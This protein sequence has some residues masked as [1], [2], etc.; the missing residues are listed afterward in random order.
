MNVCVIIP[1]AGKSSRYGESDKLSQ[2]LGGRSVLLRTVELFTKREEVKSIIVAGPPSEL[3]EFKARY[4]A[5]LGFHG[6]A[7]VPGGREHRWETVRNALNSG[8]IPE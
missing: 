4:G 7:I 6:A 5:T 1:A 8:A 2:D 3:D